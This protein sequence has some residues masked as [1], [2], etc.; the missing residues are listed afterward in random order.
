[1]KKLLG[2]ERRAFLLNLLKQKDLQLQVRNSQKNECF[3]E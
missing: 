2:E 3:L 1:M